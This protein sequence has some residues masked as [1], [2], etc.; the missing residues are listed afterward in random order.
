MWPPTAPAVQ[1]IA[2]G[3]PLSPQRGSRREAAAGGGSGCCAQRR[4]SRRS[5][6]AHPGATRAQLRLVANRRPLFVIGHLRH[7]G[8][9]H[10]PPRGPLRRRLRLGLRPH[11]RANPNPNP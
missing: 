3:C 6:A 5:V 11:R 8:V 10:L 7:D 1:P 2:Q 9:R 4:R